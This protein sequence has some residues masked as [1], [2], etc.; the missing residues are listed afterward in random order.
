MMLIVGNASLC[1]VDG[2]DAAIRSGGNTVAFILHMNLLAWGRLIVLVFKELR[3]RYGSAVDKVVRKYL[4]E[5]GYDDRYALKQYYDRLNALDQQLSQMLKDFVTIV[6]KDYMKFQE[7]MN[8]SLNP[9]AGTSEERRIASVQFA[10]D[11][12]VAEERIMRTPEE[13]RYWLGEGWNR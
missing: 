10:R 2:V 4:A 1:L 9:A 11:L 13:L 6:E 8:K 7:G 12:G 5:L 3:I